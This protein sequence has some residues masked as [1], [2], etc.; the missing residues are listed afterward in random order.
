MINIL[1][2]LSHLEIKNKQIIEEKDRY[3]Q[4]LQGALEKEQKLKVELHDR[5]SENNQVLAKLQAFRQNINNM[6]KQNK[7][8]ENIK[9]ERD[10]LEV[11]LK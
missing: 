3:V 10:F 11:T 9:I 7:D 8:L 4:N 5:N 6:E 1:F 2:I